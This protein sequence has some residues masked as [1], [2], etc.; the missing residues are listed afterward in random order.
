MRRSGLIIVK[1]VYFISTQPTSKHWCCARTIR[2]DTSIT[3]QIPSEAGTQRRV[4]TIFKV[5]E[6][7]AV[8][9]AVLIAGPSNAKTERVQYIHLHDPMLGKVIAGVETVDHASDAQL[10]TYARNISRQRIE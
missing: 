8:A 7:V 1:P 4:P 3:R 5:A 2:P 10:V 6:A 9:G